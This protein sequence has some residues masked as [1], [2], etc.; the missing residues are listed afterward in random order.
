MSL[1]LFRIGGRTLGSFDCRDVVLQGLLIRTPVGVILLGPLLHTKHGCP[2]DSEEVDPAAL[3]PPN[4]GCLLEHP[5]VPV[6]RR[7]RD[8][9]PPG[10]LL[11]GRRLQGEQVH[12]LASMPTRK[13]REDS[14]QVIGSLSRIVHNN[15]NYTCLR[16]DWSKPVASTRRSWRP[17]SMWGRRSTSARRTSERM[18]DMSDNRNPVVDAWFEKY[19]NPQKDLVQAVRALSWTPTRGSPR[20]SSGKRRRLSTRVTS[21]RSIRSPSSTCR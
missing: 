14:V 19:D 2:V 11:D 13:R 18:A 1:L 16:R 7:Q 17:G 4:Q 6:D 15:V 12:D 21:P 3:L 8:A 10:K 5:D 9:D 20:S